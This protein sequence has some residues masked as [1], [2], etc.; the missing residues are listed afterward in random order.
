MCATSVPTYGAL[1][2][3]VWCS[4]NTAQC[5]C[6]HGQVCVSLEAGTVESWETDAVGSARWKEGWGA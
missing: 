5:I 1:E 4:G 3:G 2:R 6:D